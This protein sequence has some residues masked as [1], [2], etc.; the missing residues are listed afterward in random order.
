MS[1]NYNNQTN[2][3]NANDASFLANRTNLT[4]MNVF[5]MIEFL[6]GEMK[7]QYNKQSEN[8]KF[9]EEKYD[10]LKKKIYREYRSRIIEL[11]N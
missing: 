6:K 2:L 3:K 1:V 10:I 4:N 7:K 8:I 11:I 5:E 9:L